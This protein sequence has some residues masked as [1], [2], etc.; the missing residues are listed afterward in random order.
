LRWSKELISISPELL[1]SGDM[2]II[3]NHYLT[4]VVGDK[5]I[6]SDLQDGL[7]RFKRCFEYIKA[8]GVFPCPAVLQKRGD[9][10]W[11]LDGYRRLTALFYL[12]GY[13]RTNNPGIPDLNVRE[14]Q[15]TW[16]AT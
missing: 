13:F 14:C 16:V 12:S 15:E 1:T 6:Y 4:Y 11:V 8:T 5:T 7:A 3:I 10:F 2:E 9:Q